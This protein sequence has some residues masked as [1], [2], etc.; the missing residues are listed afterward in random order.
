MTESVT[1]SADESTVCVAGVTYKAEQL[2]DEDSCEGCAFIDKSVMFC[3]QIPC[4]PDKR[5]DGSTFTIFVRVE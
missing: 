3:S 5:E 4:S 1:V 2:E